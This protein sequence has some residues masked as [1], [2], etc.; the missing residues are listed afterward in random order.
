[1]TDANDRSRKALE[2]LHN[3][4]TDENSSLHFSDFHEISESMMSGYARFVKLGVPG[5]TVALAMLGATVNL[6]R[7]FEMQEELP[8]LLRGLASSL[9]SERRQSN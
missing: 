2:G 6:Y 8:D 7:M 1:M 4:L 3:L 9:E 5:Q